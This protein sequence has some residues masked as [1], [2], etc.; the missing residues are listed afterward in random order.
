M[1]KEE[2]LGEIIERVALGDLSPPTQDLE[3]ALHALSP[4]YETNKELIETI[5]FEIQKRQTVATIKEM[6]K[7]NRQMNQSVRWQKWMV[8][9]T[10]VLAI[11]TFT[12]AILTF[13]KSPCTLP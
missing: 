5:K 4:S 11:A 1:S 6:E 13:F 12:L 3:K 9:L 2:E 10:G 8:I 7:S